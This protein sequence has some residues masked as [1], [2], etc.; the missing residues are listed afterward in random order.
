[1][2]TIW[3]VLH[4]VALIG[5]LGGGMAV[6]VA[7][8]AMKRMD[9]SL[10]GAVVDVQAALYRALLGPGSAVTVLSGLFLTFG[11]YGS[12]SKDVAAWLGVMQVT[13]VLAALVTLLGA[14]PAAQR[15]TRLEPI[16]DGAAAFDVARRRMALSGAL[17]G[18]LG[19]V[20]MVAGALYRVG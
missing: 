3:R 14:M 9:R 5:W 8:L 7:G 2:N 11:M 10:W 6:M 1:M 18:A 4:F 12:L 17:A 20:A 16:G 13:G 19:A 15:L